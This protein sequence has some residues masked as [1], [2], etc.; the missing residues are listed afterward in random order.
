MKVCVLCPPLIYIDKR[1]IQGVPQKN[2]T[3]FL[4]Y[5]SGQIEVSYIWPISHENWYP[6]LHLE[7]TNFSERF[8]DAE[9][10]IPTVSIP[11]VN[12]NI[13]KILKRLQN[14]NLQ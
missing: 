2:E 6:Y 11:D 14:K 8:T 7:Y 13:N 12:F 3:G 4:A 9:I 1:F 10:L 5:S